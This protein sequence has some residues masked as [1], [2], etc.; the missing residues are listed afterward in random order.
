MVVSSIVENLA[1]ALDTAS[2]KAVVIFACRPTPRWA[3]EVCSETHARRQGA[4]CARGGIVTRRPGS[5]FGVLSE[6]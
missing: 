1:A 3:G 4:E 6:L 5:V 2:T